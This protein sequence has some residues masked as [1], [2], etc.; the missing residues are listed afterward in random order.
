MT[1]PLGEVATAQACDLLIEGGVVVTMNPGREVLAGAS[2]A[3]DRGRIVGVGGA[4]EVG[5]RFRPRQRIDAARRVVVPG[6]VNCHFHTATEPIARGLVPDDTAFEE[7]VF[8]W[9][10]PIAA[11][12]S[13][14]DE[15]LSALLGAVE[16]L[17]SGVTCVVEAATGWSLEAVADSFEEAGIRGRVGRRVWD[18]PARPARFAQSTPEAVA[19]LERIVQLRRAGGRVRGTAALVGHATCSDELW[20]AARALAD[21]EGCGLSFHLSPHR[22][23][24]EAFLAEF[25]E[26]PVEHLARLG[27][28]GPDAVLVHGVELDDAEVAILAET[29]CNVCHCP[30]TGLKV[31]YGLSAVGKIPELAVAGVNLCLGTDGSNAANT[32]DLHHAAYL[33]AGLFKDARRDPSLLGAA[34]AFEMATLG[35]AAAIGASGELGS[36]E[37]GKLADVVLHDRDRPEWTPLHDVANQ[38]VWSADGRSVHTVLVE[39]RVVVENGRVV[40]VDEE[41]LYAEAQ[42]AAE[43]L[44]TRLGLAGPRPWGERPLR[45]PGDVPRP[46]SS[47]VARA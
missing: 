11:A 27:I 8:G 36:I 29:R 45:P 16:S 42:A 5:A 21:A 24:P 31:A 35:G 26:R 18:R 7:N 6:L 20:R 14:E 38:L 39:G 12:L 23:D 17:R 44:L 47:D 3:I 46:L 15:R 22:S 43:R 10:S 32:A 40:A 25:G 30:M 2:V 37:V 19:A 4:A 1:D 34:R 33:A 13:E 28:L 41:R 9:L